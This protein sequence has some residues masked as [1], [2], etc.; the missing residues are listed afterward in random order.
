[1]EPR[2]EEDN[3]SYVI[4]NL[5]NLFGKVMS[6]DVICAVVE[7]CEGDCKYKKYHESIVVY[8]KSEMQLCLLIL[9]IVCAAQL[10]SEPLGTQFRCYRS[11]NGTYVS[12]S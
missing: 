12:R 4:E 11:I 3:Y 6:K 8:S 10:V 5:M 1:M 7:S 2:A 9:P